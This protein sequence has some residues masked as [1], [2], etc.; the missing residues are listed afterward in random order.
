MSE[1]RLTSQ[2]GLKFLWC[3]DA[4]QCV[5]VF[6]R[7]TPC[8]G[9]RRPF[10]ATCKN[11]FVTDPTP[12]SG[13]ESHDVRTVSVLAVAT[14]HVPLMEVVSFGGGITVQHLTQGTIMLGY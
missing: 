7:N 10:I 2:S 11:L 3:E 12:L 6:W 8:F 14:L 5:C 4:T 1:G 13:D 9:V